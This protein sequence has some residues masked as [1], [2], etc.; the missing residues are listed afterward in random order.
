MTKIALS[1]I[2]DKGIRWTREW[3]SVFNFWHIWIELLRDWAF[4][5]DH[6]WEWKKYKFPKD[7]KF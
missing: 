6:H 3:V 5:Q 4:E 1:Y 7:I 2:D